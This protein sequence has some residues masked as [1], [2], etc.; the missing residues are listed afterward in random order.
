MDWDK[1]FLLAG[2]GRSRWFDPGDGRL[3]VHQFANTLFEGWNDFSQS[4]TFACRG[5]LKSGKVSDARPHSAASVG[6]HVNDTIED[7]N[8]SRLRGITGVQFDASM[9]LWPSGMVTACERF[10]L[11]RRRHRPAPA[12]LAFCR[13]RGSVPGPG[14]LFNAA[15]RRSGKGQDGGPRKADAR[16]RPPLGK[17][18]S[19][20]DGSPC[21][22]V[23]QSNREAETASDAVGVNLR[24]A[25]RK[26]KYRRGALAGG[27]RR[28]G[29]LR[30]VGGDVVWAIAIARPQAGTKPRGL[31]SAKSAGGYCR[32]PRRQPERIVAGVSLGV[33][34]CFGRGVGVA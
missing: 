10:R 6:R 14:R 9:G 33:G 28:L 32:K 24:P 17:R 34:G 7:G 18:L 11:P 3:A 21:G 1:P 13:S 20:P 5:T 26:R 4:F 8:F 15:G 22:S 29:L 2:F 31:Y 19:R 30:S 27:P 16:S 25:G 23:R 12:R